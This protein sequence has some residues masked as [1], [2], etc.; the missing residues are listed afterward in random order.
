MAKN[1]QLTASCDCPLSHKSPQISKQF[2]ANNRKTW[3]GGSR[4][5]AHSLSQQKIDEYVSKYTGLTAGVRV[6]VCV[7]KRDQSA[8]ECVN[9][10]RASAEKPKA[11]QENIKE[12]QEKRRRRWGRAVPTNYIE[13]LIIQ[14]DK[15]RERERP[16]KKDKQNIYMEIWQAADL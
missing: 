13:M 15:E 5:T 9:F 11:A 4:G 1:R 6:C 12:K 10:G 14:W 7:C 8:E 3:G 2:D 16:R